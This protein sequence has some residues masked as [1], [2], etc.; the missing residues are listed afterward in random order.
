MGTYVQRS[1]GPECT[2]LTLAVHP[3]PRQTMVVCDMSKVDN[4]RRTKSQRQPR[5]V[6]T[7]TPRRVKAARGAESRQRTGAAPKGA[8]PTV[9]D[10]FLV[11]GL[12]ASAGG[13]EAVRKL[14]AALPADTGMAFV[15]I[16]HLDPTHKSMM[17]DLLARDTEMSVFQA[18]DGMS[19][20]P[21][22]L[23]VIPPQADLSVHDGL[24]RFS[25]PPVRQGAHLPFD[26]FLHSLADNYGERAVCVILS[27]TGS[28]GSVGLRAVSEKGGLVIAQDPGETAYEGMPRSAIATG[29]VDLV[30][31]AAKIPQVLI[32][33]AQH[34][35]LI[36]ASSGSLDHRMM[37][38]M[39][40]DHDHR[41]SSLTRGSR[42]QPLQASHIAS[43]HP[44]PDGRSQRQGDRRLYQD[45]A[46][47]MAQ[48]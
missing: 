21:N 20:Q 9:S 27:G 40:A 2:D 15:L 29:A 35:E 38:Q 4:A 41:A 13:L 36:S 1:Q 43:S 33:H 28:D 6:R 26:F 23:Y 10:R 12:G 17:V 44:A 34:P 7:N 39:M 25:Q 32:R 8:V 47:K 16:Q 24:L 19:N 42:F 11:V 48:S 18:A 37:R 31:P 3:A 14:L 46:Q 22:S 5:K 30:L 45:T